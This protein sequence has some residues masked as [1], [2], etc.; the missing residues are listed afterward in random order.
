M[1]KRAV[2]LQALE[3]T[4]AD[5]ARLVRP[6]NQ[7]GVAGHANPHARPVLAA[8][9][10]LI[11]VDQAYH[12][13]ISRILAED[14][15]PL[16]P[17]NPEDSTT[18]ADATP[19]ALSEAFGRVR[20]ETLAILRAL[21]PGQWQRAGLLD[22]RGRITLRFLIQELVEH[23]IERTNQLVELIQAWRRELKRRAAA[24]QE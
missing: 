17:I 15:P 14:E 8:L 24:H 10:Q 1:T 3:S 16:P 22:G 21:G 5:V 11:Y 6:L 18:G 20:A 23:D 4:P 13:R 19:A 2:L 7:E 12:T 9:G